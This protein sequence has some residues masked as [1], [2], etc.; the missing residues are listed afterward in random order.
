MSG[1]KDDAGI[2]SDH[3]EFVPDQMARGSA[4]HNNASRRLDPARIKS[5]ESKTS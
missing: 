1:R 3:F 2:E 5:L 4:N